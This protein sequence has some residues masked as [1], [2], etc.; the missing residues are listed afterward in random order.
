MRKQQADAVGSPEVEI[1]ADDR[2]EKMAALDGAREDLRQTDFDLLKREPMRVAGGPVG[3]C[4]GRRQSRRPAIKEC[5]DICWA[6]L[7][8]DRL[9]ARRIGTR[10]EPI[11]ETLK[12]DVTVC[13]IRNGARRF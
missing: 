2:L 11:V 13:T 7:I 1:L 9:Q 3:R 4:Q 5:L 10:E 12:W 6:K 8:A